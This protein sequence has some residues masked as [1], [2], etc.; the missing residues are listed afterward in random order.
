MKLRTILPILAVVGVLAVLFLPAGLF[1]AEPIST[2]QIDRQCIESEL[3]NCVVLGAGHFNIEWG[4]AE[5]APWL[6]WQTQ[7][8]FTPE[9]GVKGGFVLLA[10][11]GDAWTVLDKGF[12]A[13]RYLTP[14]LGQEGGLLHVPGYSGGTGAY[15]ADRLYL[16]SDDEQGWQRIDLDSWLATIGELLPEG[17]EIWKGVDYGFSDWFYEDFTA[18]TPLWRGD[19]ANCCPSGGWAI[20]H[21]EIEDAVLVAR[22]VDY[23]PPTGE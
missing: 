10:R 15:N 3:H 12:D 19:D 21:F 9:D 1:A 22:R 17:L 18:R 5:G 11:E 20:V 4:D 14:L 2:K 6:A 16:L 23:L 7:A 8:G 13:A